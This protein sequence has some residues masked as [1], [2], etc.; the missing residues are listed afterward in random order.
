[1]AAIAVPITVS[2]AIGADG[3]A[4]TPPAVDFLGVAQIWCDEI[5]PNYLADV[6]L[7]RN[8]CRPAFAMLYGGGTETMSDYAYSICQGI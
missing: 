8:Y 7:A 1:V 5:R 2:A 4:R 3:I 6:M